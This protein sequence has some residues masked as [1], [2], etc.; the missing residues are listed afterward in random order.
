M[1]ICGFLQVYNELKKGNLIRCLNNLKY[2]CDYIAVYDDGSTDG[3]NK[4][5]KRYGCD[6]IRNEKND[7]LAERKHEQELLEFA[8]KKHPDITWFFLLDA[9]EVLDANGTK[10]I[11]K[12]CETADKEGYYFPEITLWRSDCWAR[13]DYLGHGRFLRLWKNTGKIRFNTSR[14]LHQDY[15]YQGPR[16]VGDAPFSVIHYGYATK[17]AI[18]RR[19]IERTKL[20]V[21]F[22]I[23]K[24]CIDESNMI[25]VRIPDYRFPKGCKPKR[26]RKPKPI[27]YPECERMM[28]CPN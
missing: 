14:G 3:S 28:R 27:R 19:W 22:N 2:Y 21:P 6:I 8:I 12:F 17:E 16:T 18:I 4:V 10:N 24:K 1:K 26:T 15:F 5:L 11:R 9:D 23:R 25:L 13:V 20:G 7:F